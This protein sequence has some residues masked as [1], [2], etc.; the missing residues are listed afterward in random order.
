MQQH[1]HE[2]KRAR[3]IKAGKADIGEY[4]AG[5]A[6]QG[7]APKTARYT[8]GMLGAGDVTVPDTHFARYLF[9]LHKGPDSNS[10]NY[11]KNV[12]WNPNGAE[13]LNAIDRYYNQHHDAVKHMQAHPHFGHLFQED[14]MQ[15]NFPAFWKNWVSI[16]P[17]EAA[18]G[19]AGRA[20][21]AQNEQTD[22]RP[23]WEAINPHIEQAMK[24]ENEG[25]DEDV[26]H[27]LAYQT[28]MQH[29]AWVE[30]YGEMPAMMLYYAHLVPKLLAAYHD[31]AEPKEVLPD[32]PE[33]EPD[34]YADRHFEPE[35]DPSEGV[36]RP[37]GNQPHVL[38]IHA[39]LPTMLK[40][41]LSP[42]SKSG[43]P[44]V[45]GGH[46]A[47][48]TG[49]NPRFDAKVHGENASLEKELTKRGMKFEKVRGKYGSHENS[50]L[51]HNPKL[52]HM[53]DIGRRYGQESILHAEGPHAHLIYTHGP[54]AGK[55][56]IADTQH[57]YQHEPED[58]Y[59]TIPAGNKD[60]SDL[61]FTWS[62]DW[63]KFHDVRPLLAEHHAHKK[64]GKT[65]LYEKRIR[66]LEYLN[67]E[68]DSLLKAGEQH[69]SVLPGIPKPPLPTKQSA[70]KYLAPTAG[71]DEDFV[72]FQG[73]RVRPGKAFVYPTGME[74][75]MR[76]RPVPF[77]I[78]GHTPEGGI[79]GVEAAKWGEH[80]PEDIKHIAHGKFEMI[81]PAENEEAEPQV[82]NSS[83]HGD[84]RYNRSDAQH[85]LIH[86]TDMKAPKAAQS[87]EGINAQYSHWRQMGPEGKG[88]MAYVKRSGGGVG[89]PNFD[90]PH[91]E[92]AYN[93]LARDVFGLG[94]Y[95]PNAAL[96][97]HP[98]TNEPHAVI[99][100]VHGGE[101]PEL[102]PKQRMGVTTGGI[103]MNAHAKALKELGDKGELDKLAMM[104]QI[105][106]NHDRHQHNYL[107]T[108]GDEKA[109]LKLIDHGYNFAENHE[110]PSFA[111]R[112]NDQH[113][114]K[115]FTPHYI[116][117]YNRIKDGGEG[118]DSQHE[119]I[120]PAAQEWLHGIKPEKL[121]A[122]MADMGIPKKYIDEASYRLTNL[123]QHLGHYPYL[124]RKRAL[125]SHFTPAEN[126]DQSWYESPGTTGGTTDAADV[127]AG[128]GLS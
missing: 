63:S 67:V 127:W 88:P 15:A 60:G 117:A 122:H 75:T 111:R 126:V 106:G 81:T 96:F 35:L 112:P 79:H 77:K 123:Q 30:K 83:L 10:I 114:M 108:P 68:F 61:H 69:Q 44:A 97:R 101:H 103:K 22:H 13:T 76:A 72:P 33:I 109:P 121:E 20:G 27:H 125:E 73:K 98:H 19:M 40:D 3:G 5:P 39:F 8:M 89:D 78:L 85:Q 99:E 52:K 45:N 31:G 86:G 59:T 12:L 116:H 17:H 46:Y 25:Q 124:S 55:M 36:S 57:T 91:R 28:A 113:A 48:V 95:V 41:A 56:H 16:A 80:G 37:F 119:P 84:W 2:A 32:H 18:R 49:E 118:G 100:R 71:N 92:V 42:D 43:H 128:V 14:P 64:F 50:F 21:E 54:Y 94:D 1:L 90:E 29:A 102:K 38:P 107:M 51:I 87:E 70:T 93:N 53:I 104:N 120:H 6:V 4:T 65:E 62:P 7:L 58:Y 110:I 74:N 24:S 66:Q 26:L 115:P 9:G 105:M 82:V 47:I 23:F 34:T 11:L